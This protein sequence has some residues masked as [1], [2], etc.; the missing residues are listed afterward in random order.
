MTYP[1]LGLY[2]GREHVF[3][4]SATTA[5]TPIDVRSACVNPIC[6]AHWEWLG[7][8]YRVRGLEKGD[9]ELVKERN[10][11]FAGQLHF[12]IFKSHTRFQLQVT[13]TRRTSGANPMHDF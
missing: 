8:V 5:A 3:N 13:Q 9:Y 6:D 7:K 10:G 2:R 12:T 1:G 11:P 4:L